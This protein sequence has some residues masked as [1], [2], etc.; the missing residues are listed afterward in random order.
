MD[1]IDLKIKNALGHYVYAL[2]DPFDNK[3]FYV[4]KASGNNRV[5]DHLKSTKLETEKTKKIQEII[6]KNAEPKIEI[7]RYDLATKEIAFEVEA[8]I[9]DALGIENLT[10]VVRGHKIERGRLRL[11]EVK[12]LYGSAPTNI[13]TIK[14]RYMTFYINKTYS[15]NLSEIEIYDATRQFWTNVSKDKRTKNKQGKLDY[16]IAL[17]IY[18]SVVIRVY[19][20]V[21][22]FEA[23]STFSTRTTKKTNAF[24]FVGNKIEKHA[25]LGKKLVNQDGTRIKANQQGYGYIN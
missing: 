3:I 5:F 14:E 12:R 2:I 21:D 25:L 8:S 19:S 6:F 18:D 17:S 13:K 7:L 22:W 23:G 15:T 10:N 11:S 20:I 1:K 16:P 4:G 24:E 9:I